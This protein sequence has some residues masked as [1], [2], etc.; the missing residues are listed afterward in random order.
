[1]LTRDR[2]AKVRVR[3]HVVK[4]AA[5]RGSIRG[6]EILDAT[7][8]DPCSFHDAPA[9]LDCFFGNVLVRIK[10]DGLRDDSWLVW[11][12]THAGAVTR[13]GIACFGWTQV[14]STMR[15]NTH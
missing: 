5:I 10:L 4:D 2:T 3:I 8:I 6:L 11:D 14:V 7:N 1:M 12:L 15:H 13:L 9:L